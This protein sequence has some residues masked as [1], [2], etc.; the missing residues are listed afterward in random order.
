[1]N[2]NLSNRVI[3]IKDIDT[4]TF[5]PNK[6]TFSDGFKLNLS[7]EAIDKIRDFLHNIL[8]DEMSS[9]WFHVIG[10]STH[11]LPQHSSIPRDQE[12]GSS[13]SIYQGACHFGALHSHQKFYSHVSFN[14]R[15]LTLSFER[16]SESIDS[17]AIHIDEGLRILVSFHSIQKRNI[18]VN[19][20]HENQGIFVLIPLK[21]APTVWKMIKSSNENSRKV[22]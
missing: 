5:T 16:M 22:R 17:L 18:L 13:P 20:Y 21:Y 19:K 6:K 11:S 9:I 10:N 14:N 3:K 2:I 12:A 1:L 4:S 8:F 7:Q 15:V